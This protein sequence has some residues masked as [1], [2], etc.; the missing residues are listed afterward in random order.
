MEEIKC[1]AS[2][3]PKIKTIWLVGLSALAWQNTVC[4]G[5]GVQRDTA[6]PQGGGDLTGKPVDP[7]VVLSMSV[8]HH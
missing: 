1:L 2:C 7:L 3:C 8:S 4:A 6:V 5:R